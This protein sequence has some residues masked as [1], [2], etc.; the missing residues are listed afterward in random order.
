MHGPVVLIFRLSSKFCLGQLWPVRIL[1]VVTFS[2]SFVNLYWSLT[3]ICISQ[4]LFLPF[5]LYL[6]LINVFAS[7]IHVSLC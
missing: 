4:V 2:V 1:K 7:L 6:F 5:A 3:I